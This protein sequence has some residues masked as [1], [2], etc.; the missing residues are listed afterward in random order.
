MNDPFTSHPGL[1]A[2]GLVMDGAGAGLSTDVSWGGARG[3]L[4]AH[5][6]VG[7][8]GKLAGPEPGK[9]VCPGEGE[10]PQLAWD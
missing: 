8:G 4:T 9:K 7:T 3:K 6:G 1:G 5:R 2:A 10:L